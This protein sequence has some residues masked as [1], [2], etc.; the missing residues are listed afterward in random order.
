MADSTMPAGLSPKRF[1]MRSDSEPW[2]TP[3]RRAR[4]SSFGP[5]DQR[6]KALGDAVDFRLIF[7]IGILDDLKCF[8]IGEITGIDAHLF[9]VL[10]GFH[11]GLGHKVDVGAEGN[12]FIAGGAELRRI[13]ARA[14]ASLTPGA[15]MR[16]NWHPASASCMHCATVA[17]TSWVLRVAHT[18]DGD[19][20]IA[21]D[22]HL[23]GPTS[24]EKAAAPSEAIADVGGK[25]AGVDGHLFARWDLE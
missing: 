8:F 10:D 12:V 14:L 21:A 20:I 1:I 15:V 2:L 6:A 17:S 4:P 7:F 19:G 23:A 3:M 11:G 16:T 22:A 25:L 24:R 9:H 18:L 5:Q 13:S